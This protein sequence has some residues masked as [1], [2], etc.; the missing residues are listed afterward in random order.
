MTMIQSRRRF[1][2]SL[3]SAGAA[4]LVGASNSFAQEAP[5]ETTTIR[6]ARSRSICIAPQYVVGDLLRAEG[7]TDI[8]YV[9][10]DAG[11]GQSKMLGRGEID[12]TLHFSPL[13]LIPIDAGEKISIIG[14]V[15]VGCFELL[16]TGRI[17]SIADLKGK[18]VGVPD[19]GTSPHVFVSTMAAHVGLDPA[20]DINWVTSPSVAP[21]ELFAA[22]KIDAW[23]GFPPEPQELRARKVGHVVVNS[24][25][26]R[27]WSQYY[28]CMLGGNRGFIR[29]N[30]VASKRV[31][32]AILKA[33][34]FCVSDPTGAARR[35]VDGG[36][37]TQYDYA[38]QTLK[39]V[40]YNKWREYDPEDTIRFF[41]LRLR[42][43][44]LI[45]SSPN[46]I[47]AEAVDWRFFN[48][49]K[50]ELKG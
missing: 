2:A 24:S 47:I 46:K 19:L 27:P 35:M 6:L 20:K 9:V 3:S 13:L 28:C 4:G 1:L 8:R 49:L 45:K 7:F 41:A 11:M 14:G 22:G 40:P 37:T 36:F 42:E 15:H 33:T 48:E 39:E 34:D 18:T 25:V 43:A 30:P 23:L 26:D 5:P 10:T 50:R 17:R 38:L 32:R 12:L 29:R 16:A 44:G 31:L 21:M